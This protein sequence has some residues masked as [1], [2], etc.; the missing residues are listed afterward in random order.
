VDT[1]PAN[2]FFGVSPE[3][4]GF[5]FMFGSLALGIVVA[6]LTPPPPTHIQDLVEDIR[7][8]GARA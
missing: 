6:L 2:W 4:I 5:V 8:P 7:V 1:D 3:G